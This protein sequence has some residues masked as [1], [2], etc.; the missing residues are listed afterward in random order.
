MIDVLVCMD[1]WLVDGWM[2][3]WVDGWMGG[4][5]DGWMDE[6]VGTQCYANLMSALLYR[7]GSYFTGVI[8]SH[9]A[10]KEGYESQSIPREG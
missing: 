1:E 8:S 6:S 7:A 4:W 5:M 9:K 10:P 3:R 2:E